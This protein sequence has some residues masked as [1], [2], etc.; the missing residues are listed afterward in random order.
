MLSHTPLF[1]TNFQDYILL[2]IKKKTTTLMEVDKK[3][4]NVLVIFL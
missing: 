4:L 2:I 1:N 3:F